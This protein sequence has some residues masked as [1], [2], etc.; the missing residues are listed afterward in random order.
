MRV[1][2]D[3]NILIDVCFENGEYYKSSYGALLRLITNQNTCYITSSCTID[4]FY[5]IKKYCSK[6]EAKKRLF[7]LFNMCE[8]VPIT[9]K[10]ICLA[11]ESN[12]DD[13]EDAIVE[14][15][16]YTNNCDYILTR[17]DKDFKKSLKKVITPKE[18]NK[19]YKI[20]I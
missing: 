6:E 7:S 2:I 16:A 5:I 1:L 8:V 20:Q 3:T 4:I 12:I 18:I 17:N 19:K 10:E 9:E 11:L 14:S 13:Y 15:V